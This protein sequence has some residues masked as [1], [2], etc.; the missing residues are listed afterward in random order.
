MFVFQQLENFVFTCMIHLTTQ[1]LAITRNVY[2]TLDW[3][4][5]FWAKKS[6]KI[7]HFKQV[8]LNLPSSSDQSFLFYDFPFNSS[9]FPHS[10]SCPLATTTFSQT[11]DS[12][13]SRMSLFEAGTSE[14]GGMG[15]LAG[16]ADHNMNSPAEGKAHTFPFSSF[17]PFPF[18]PRE[19]HDPLRINLTEALAAEESGDSATSS[20]NS[21]KRGKLGRPNR[22]E[23]SNL[24]GDIKMRG[25]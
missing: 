21:G 18:L 10:S 17:P 14:A 22:T 2:S 3:W 24:S 1:R 16:S 7:E 23:N 11:Y 6:D 13:S 15:K 8:L 5:W 19:P 4:I 12:S 25:V 20:P 9:L